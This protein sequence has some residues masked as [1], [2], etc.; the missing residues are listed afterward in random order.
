MPFVSFLQ[1][2]DGELEAEWLNA[3]GFPQL[4]RAFEEVS[5]TTHP[6][7]TTF[8]LDLCPVGRHKREIK[9]REILTHVQ[10]ANEK[11]FD[12][13]VHLTP[14]QKGRRRREVIDYMR[15]GF[16]L[17]EMSLLICKLAT[18]SSAPEHQLSHC[19]GGT[20]EE[21]KVCEKFRVHL[22]ESRLI[23]G[24]LITRF[25]SIMISNGVTTVRWF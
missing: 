12:E 20:G 7:V 24:M 15:N 6:T 1:I 4:T 3:A 25:E 11:P 18:A 5:A 17:R 14:L 16:F 10:S 22:I 13:P 19:H 23:M 2:T 8:L 9:R 21:I